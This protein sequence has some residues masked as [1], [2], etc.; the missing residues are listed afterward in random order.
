MQFKNN[1]QRSTKTVRSHISHV[2]ITSYLYPT[3]V[4]THFYVHAVL[5]FSSNIVA[6]ATDKEDVY[7]FLNALYRYYHSNSKLAIAASYNS[8]NFHG[9]QQ[10]QAP[11]RSLLSKIEKLCESFCE[12]YQRFFLVSVSPLVYFVLERPVCYQTNGNYIVCTD[13]LYI[14]HPTPCSPWKYSKLI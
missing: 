6:S 13:H 14:F 3:S 1:Q 5:H 11:I 7:V 9:S 2:F 12:Y 8:I 4:S 10:K